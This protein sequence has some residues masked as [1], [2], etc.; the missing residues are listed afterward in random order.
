MVQQYSEI[1][2]FC[3]KDRP[4]ACESAHANARSAEQEAAA[5]RHAEET[6]SR[7]TPLGRGSEEELDRWNR[8]M[9]AEIKRLRAQCEGV[10][11]GCLSAKTH[12]KSQ[13]RPYLPSV[14]R[15]LRKSR[16]IR[17]MQSIEIS[18]GHT[19]SHSRWL[20]HEPKASCSIW[21]TIRAT[22]S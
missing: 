22:R 7:S 2:H 12:R 8:E 20:V 16:F 3:N 14:N 4:V 13:Q 17:A 10:K 11:S 21:A 6:G 15:A 5:R 1:A 19:A 18:F 9:T